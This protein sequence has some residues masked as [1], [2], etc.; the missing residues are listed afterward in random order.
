MRFGDLWEIDRAA[1]RFASRQVRPRQDCNRLPLFFLW[2][3]RWVRNPLRLTWYAKFKRTPRLR[4]KAR[5]VLNRTRSWMEHDLAGAL[6]V[7]VLRDQG[8]AQTFGP[9]TMGYLFHV[10]FATVEGK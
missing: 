8:D 1:A 7:F 3:V 9:S 5:F 2:Y 4:G 6:L 10:F